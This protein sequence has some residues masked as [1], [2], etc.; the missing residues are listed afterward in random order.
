MLICH[1]PRSSAHWGYF[2]QF[3]TRLVQNLTICNNFNLIP[4]VHG[5]QLVLFSQSIHITLEFQA[6]TSEGWDGWRSTFF[7][8]SSGFLIEFELAIAP[9]RVG[10]PNQLTTGDRPPAWCF[11]LRIRFLVY[12]V[13]AQRVTPRDSPAAAAAL[14]L[15]PLLSECGGS[16]PQLTA[17]ATTGSCLV[18]RLPQGLRRTNT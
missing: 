1:Y 5:I 14:W 8:V 7:T 12:C 11:R 3:L 18:G 13:T 2:R 4:L 10:C 15:R 6:P 9:T 17:T 16:R